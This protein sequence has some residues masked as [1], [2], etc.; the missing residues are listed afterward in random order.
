MPEDVSVII[1]CYNEQEY[2]S[3]AIE[4]VFNQTAFDAIKEIGV[5]DDGSSD[6]SKAVIRPYAD[7]CPK[8][9]YIYQEN[10]GLAVAR[11]T[12]IRNTTGA[13][14]ALLDG[15]DMWLEQKLEKQLA[16]LDGNP[17][18]GLLYTDFYVFNG[19]QRRV[20]ARHFDR[21]DEDTL[22][23][24]FLKGGPIIPSTTIITRSCL[25]QVGL[26]D[27]V[28][29]RGQD[30]DMWLRIAH[31]WPIHHMGAPLIRKR[32]REDSLGAD[33]EKKS[34]HLFQITEKIAQRYPELR[35]YKRRRVA[36]IYARL[37]RRM[38]LEGRR[39]KAVRAALKAIRRDISSLEGYLGAM[40]AV[41][42]LQQ[43]HLQKIVSLLQGVKR[44]YKKVM[45]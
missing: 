25:Q 33:A 3:D 10:K 6:D 37:A 39:K 21:G 44:G 45:A 4:S 35:P 29:R 17:E 20:Y 26:F 7:S 22:E 5:V 9:R 30:R 14:I 24:L 32:N 16:F 41:L 19:E 38:A 8:L 2:I 31:D 1:T 12:G 13:Y 43:S 36:M 34:A 42:P 27:P 18:V 11:N 15:D 23:R 40:L 28:L